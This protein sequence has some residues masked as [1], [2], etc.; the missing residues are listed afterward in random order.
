MSNPD[1]GPVC[2]I[3]PS[4]RVQPSTR[5][6]M[7]NSVVGGEV[8][9]ALTAT[10]KAVKPPPALASIGGVDCSPISAGAEKLN[11]S[12]FSERSIIVGDAL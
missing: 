8:T 3:D 6:P 2:S 12:N 11:F 4:P 7:V 9:D 5:S 10:R 1:L